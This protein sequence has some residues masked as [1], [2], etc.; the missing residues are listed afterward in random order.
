MSITVA[1]L[2]FIQVNPRDLLNCKFCN[3]LVHLIFDYVI[4][5]LIV[6]FFIQT[7]LSN[8]L[9]FVYASKVMIIF[10]FYLLEILE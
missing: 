7:C 9:L 5:D 6:D 3:S 4:K 2:Y 8:L 10:P 1:F